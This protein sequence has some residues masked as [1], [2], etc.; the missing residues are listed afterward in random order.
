MSIT[1]WLACSLPP[2]THDQVRAL[3]AASNYLHA[4][5]R[6]AAIGLLGC[7]PGDADSTFLATFST[8]M[9]RRAALCDRLVELAEPEPH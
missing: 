2:P 9:L 1:L 5:G 6:H 8:A 3:T 4:V 7:P